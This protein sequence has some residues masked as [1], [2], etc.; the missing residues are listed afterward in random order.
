MGSYFFKSFTKLLIVFMTLFFAQN[1]W[2]YSK[3]E[4]E[5]MDVLIIGDSIVG[6]ITISEDGVQNICYRDADADGYGGVNAPFFNNPSNG[7]CGSISGIPYVSNNLD[8]NDANASVNPLAVEVCNFID[9]DCDAGIDENFLPVTIYGDFDGDGYGTPFINGSSRET[10]PLPLG[11]VLD[12]TDCEDSDPSINPGQVELC[13]GIND[14]C[15]GGID[16]GFALSTF[17][18]D[19]DSDGFGDPGNAVDA[20]VAGP[21]MTTDNTDCDDSDPFLFPGNPEI[22]NGIDENCN[23]QIDEDFDVD[24]DGWSTCEG[25]CDD[26]NAA[27]NPGI[28]EGPFQ[29]GS[30]DFI[31]N[32]CD[33]VVDEFWDQDLDGYTVCEL[34]CDDL[35][36]QIFPGQAE[37]CDYVDSNCDGI[38]DND[39]FVISFLDADGDGFGFGAVDTAACD[40]PLGYVDNADDCNDAVA[41]INPIAI[42]IC[43][44]IDN[45]CNGAVDEGVTNIYFADEDGDSFGG[46][47]ITI[48]ACTAPPGFVDNSDDCD[49]QNAAIYPGATEVCNGVDDNCDGNI[50]EGL[51]ADG[52]GFSSCIDDCND[53]DNTIYP[54][55]PEL[56][57]GIDQNC[58]GNVDNG[59]TSLLTY[60]IDADNDTYGFSDPATDSISCGQPVGYVTDNTD[61]NDDDA[62]INPGAIEICDA[63]DNDCNGLINDGVATLTYYADN[64][65]DG[66][67]LN[68]SGLDSC[69]APAG[70]VLDNTD[71]DDGDALVNPGV[72]EVCNGIDDNCDGNID[73]GFDVDADGY[74]VC[75]DDCDDNNPNINPGVIEGLDPIYCDGIDNNCDGNID[76]LYDQDGDGFTFCGGDCDDTND[77]I[78]L[79]APELCDGVDQDCDGVADNGLVN[80]TYYA[81]VDG[82]G[83]G[84]PLSD[85]IS[86]DIVLG[87][88]ADNTDCND[89]D[90][91][92]YPGAPELCDGIDQD[93]DGVA[94]N[95][96]PTLTFYADADGDGFGNIAIDSVTCQLTVAG[97]VADNTD[98]DDTDNTIYP[99][100]V[101]ICDGLDQDC[102][103]VADNGL[104]T[105]T[106]YADADGDGFG[107]IAVDSVTCQLTVAGFVADNTDCDDTDNTIY[108]G[109]VEIC[110][111][112]DQDCDGVADNGL[113]TQTFYA[114][115]DGDGFG[116]AA[117]DSISCQLT[118]AG[119]VTDN[120]D[121][122]DT[123][124][125]IFP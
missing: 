3:I 100:A 116:D 80:Q 9:D 62:A 27:I 12:N 96:L 106:F 56:C 71:C 87:Y 115:A 70:Y 75:Q 24:G 10:C 84:D 103:G 125:S 65:L 60:Y 91:T 41:A 83:F 30:C 49:D 59:A 42:E 78:Y 68:G 22:C 53:A 40:I 94:D 108:P 101:E 79:G 74:T 92:I 112:I 25:D 104:A 17:Y 50:D 28:L 37:V 46:S 7:A 20:C 26:N 118:L 67:G 34:D 82:D 107:N 51:D 6:E 98:C 23:G 123:D 38:L 36:D 54:G 16:D 119:F 19:L 2:A 89:T 114:D 117:V 4:V 1:T 124:N 110:D 11:F 81:D 88:V 47:T 72:A 66:Y 5:N 31:D 77:Q 102:D 95:G 122:D 58:D 43:D 97:F 63:L 57:D 69:S 44:E 32:N 39:L 29:A 21:F 85:S 14:D 76:E 48:E 8:C 18:Y 64:D 73:E 111:G 90:N 52:D 113:A 45:N 120:T 109:A 61:C 86:C 121:C 33:G 99:G 55:A 105:L 13:N 15:A 93:C 35:N